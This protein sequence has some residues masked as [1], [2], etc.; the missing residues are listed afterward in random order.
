M[1]NVTGGKARGTTVC[2]SPC[3]ARGSRVG[4]GGGTRRSVPPPG[5][6]CY[7]TAAESC[8]P[9]GHGLPGRGSPQP[10]DQDGIQPGG[11]APWLPGR[12]GAAKTLFGPELG[13]AAPS[14][15][16]SF[17]ARP[18]LSAGAD[19]TGCPAGMFLGTQPIAGKARMTNACTQR[20]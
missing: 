2:G 6:P 10:T 5:R 12:W 11:L 4:V 7:P 16:P 20:G 19:P 13:S 14:E 15:P 18:C 17:L 8:Q 3:R 9:Q 1:L